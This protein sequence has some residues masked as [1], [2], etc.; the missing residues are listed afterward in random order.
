MQL[1]LLISVGVGV[2][3]PAITAA[4]FVVKS[5]IGKAKYY[6]T[7]EN[8]IKQLQSRDSNSD[9]IHDGH[10]ARLHEL[11]NK[12]AKLCDNVEDTKGWVRLILEHLKIPFP[13]KPKLS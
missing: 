12:V 4:T 1:E 6:T 3:I 2:G 10:D 8:E 5:F 7:M 13:R 9:G 11:E